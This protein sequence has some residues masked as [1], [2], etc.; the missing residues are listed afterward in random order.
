[1]NRREGRQRPSMGRH[2]FSTAPLAL[3]ETAGRRSAARAAF[4]STVMAALLSLA[5][6]ASDLLG[7]L[8]GPWLYSLSSVNGADLPAVYAP[9]GSAYSTT[10]YSG[11]LLFRRDGTFAGG[12]EMF[13]GCFWLDTSYAAA[14]SVVDLHNP[15]VR[16]VRSGDSLSLTFSTLPLRFVYR[17]VPLP[18]PPVSSGLYV[19]AE[20]NGRSDSLIFYDTTY[21]NGYR[22]VER[23]AFDSI[24]FT[25]RVLFRR[26][27]MDRSGWYFPNG[28]SLV[29]FT[30]VTN[31]G[32][33]DGGAGWLIL[34]PSTAQDPA[35]MRDSLALEQGELVRRGATGFGPLIERYRRAH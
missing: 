10:V 22:F 14:D 5:A 24:T 1:M 28:D 2:G 6:C 26:H 16:A 31:P 8:G 13:G 33:Y 15:S 19:L 7:P 3:T 11:D 34:R 35:R 17:H 29:G 23:V 12:A 18:H 20:V 9:P 25:D 21:A 32:A 27:R 4:A 30:E